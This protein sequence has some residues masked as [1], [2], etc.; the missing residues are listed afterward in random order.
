M[1]NLLP[2]GETRSATVLRHTRQAIHDRAL[3]VLPFSKA[4]AGRYLAETPYALRAIDLRE[5]GD[6]GESMQAAEKHNWQR[7]NRLIKGDVK[8]FPADL[9][10][11]WVACLPEAYRERCE[12]DLAARR[13]LVPVRDP[14]AADS[15]AQQTADLATLLREVGESAAALAPIFA[16]GRVDR[17]DLPHIAPALQQLGELLAAGLQLHGRLASVVIDVQA[18]PSNVTKLRA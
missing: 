10:D 5:L 9:E 7:I 14:R 11:A 18:E 17:A 15:P 3:S 8:T 12:Q 4:V 2:P 13:G 16:D 6:T 1:N